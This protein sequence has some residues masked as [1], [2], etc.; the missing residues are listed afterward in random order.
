MLRIS[1]TEKRL[2]GF[3]HIIT[4]KIPKFSG[5]RLYKTV[6][7]VLSDRCP[8]LSVLSVTLVYSGQMVGR[9]KI[10]KLGVWVSL[11]LATLC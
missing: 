4:A 11:G 1:V 5:Y 9:I 8:V 7:P 2:K 6:R 10:K 3:A